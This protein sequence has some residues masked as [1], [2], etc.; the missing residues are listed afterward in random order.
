MSTPSMSKIASGGRE[1]RWSMG[2][3]VVVWLAHD[4]SAF[5]PASSFSLPVARLARQG[6]GARGGPAARGLRGTREASHFGKGRR[7]A[8]NFSGGEVL[9]MLLF[10]IHPR[11][12]V[13]TP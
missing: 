11:P 9:R 3:R 4:G 5:W 13:I 12:A 1:E 6:W 10:F 7:D 8:S 2:L